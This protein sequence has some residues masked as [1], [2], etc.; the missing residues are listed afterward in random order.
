[1][2]ICIVIRRLSQSWGGAERVAV[3]LCKGLIQNGHEVTVLTAN[4]DVKPQGVKVKIIKINKNFSPLKILSFQH[5]IKKNMSLE[6]FDI[7]YSLTQIYPVDIYRLGGGIQ[8]HWM[9]IQYPNPV[10]RLIKYSTSLVHLA[11]YWLEN[12]IFKEDNC[13]LFVTNS[14][15]V[16]DQIAYYYKIP[17]KRIKVIYNGV[18]FEIFNTGVKKYRKSMRQM[19]HIAEDELV[20]LFISNN[21]ERKG[22]S[23]II[24]A[25]PKT[26]IKKI[27]LVIVGRGN[28]APYLSL[29]KKIKLD[30]D[31]LIFI[32]HSKETEKYY[33][34]ADIFILP[35]R[36][37]PFANVCL[38]AMACGLPVVTTITNGAS[39]LIEEGVNGF[40]L[41]DWNDSES[42]AEIIRRLRD[43]QMRE[44][45]GNNA[46]DTA[47]NFTWERHLQEISMVFDLLKK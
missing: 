7:V 35:S 12:Q 31:K 22:L 21:W 46:A 27:R 34:M 20:L 8:R 16:K 45:L 37:E 29:A 28:K 41:E 15:L 9:K 3:N 47:K 43:N 17:M 23:T 10:I 33:G 14:K 44:K 6:K 13:R 25:M 5:N 26:D 36:Y 19:H 11:M 40:V 1:M 4:A 39:E 42:L 24:K 18:D 32:G 2:R 30:S 38:E